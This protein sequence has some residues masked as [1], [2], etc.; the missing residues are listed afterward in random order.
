M[1]ERL[2]I[3]RIIED[4]E[5][6]YKSQ[7]TDWS[8]A[9]EKLPRTAL[10]SLSYRGHKECL[11][12]KHMSFSTAE[13][14]MDAPVIGT[15]FMLQDKAELDVAKLQGYWKSK[16]GLIIHSIF[17]LEYQRDELISNSEDKIG[18]PYVSNLLV[19]FVERYP[20]IIYR[21]LHIEY[22][23]KKKV[24]G[25][26]IDIGVGSYT[27]G[28]KPSVEVEGKSCQLYF[29]S[30][31]E[32]KRADFRLA[33]DSS[34]PTSSNQDIKSAIQPM[35]E[36]MAMAEMTTFDDVPEGSTRTKVPLVNFLASK[37][38]YRPFIYFKEEDV[39]ITTPFAVPLR[40]SEHKL[41]MQGLLL[42]ALLTRLSHVKTIQFTASK[43]QMLDKS[44]WAEAKQNGV[45]DYGQSK[46]C[47]G[48]KED[49]LAH[50]NEDYFSMPFSPSPSS[51][52]DEEEIQPS[53]AKRA[54]LSRKAPKEK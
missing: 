46:V 45:D 21:E 27:N 6:S 20:L 52:S 48:K 1:T 10:V 33:R 37:V 44:G 47:L 28:R 32:A 54:K 51:S 3:E 16:G 23:S 42:L 29:G 19:C 31:G 49:R 22:K 17:V 40:R 50:A 30:L 14:Q 13:S 8:M 11:F 7:P 26:S 34:S 36:L 5:V 43:I 24:V 9:W 2:T 4:S 39:I 18:V 15:S 25:G 38:A 53:R 12:K 41:D 35:L